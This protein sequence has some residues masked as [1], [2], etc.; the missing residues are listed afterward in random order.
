MCVYDVAPDTHTPFS[1]DPL[2]LMQDNVQEVIRG[3]KKKDQQI[4]LET[5]I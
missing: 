3:N 2:K 1:D 5:C 4:V